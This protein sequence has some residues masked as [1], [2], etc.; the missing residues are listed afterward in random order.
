MEGELMEHPLLI[1]PFSRGWMIG[2]R[3]VVAM[4]H[5]DAYQTVVDG[6]TYTISGHALLQSCTPH[7]IT[8]A[9]YEVGEGECL[10][11]GARFICHD[12]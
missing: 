5:R 9:D 12:R 3:P 11:C 10:W 6:V 8:D 4:I 7:T 2:E 1:D